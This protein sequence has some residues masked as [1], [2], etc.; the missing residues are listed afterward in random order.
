MSHAESLDWIGYIQRRGTLNL[1][2][3]ME[4]GF[5]LLAFLLCRG[6]RI[7]KEGGGQFYLKDFAPHL[8]AFDQEGDGELTLEEAIKALGA[9]QNGS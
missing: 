7:K 1:G 6:F 5:A 8:G 2:L 3:R 4:A 9:K